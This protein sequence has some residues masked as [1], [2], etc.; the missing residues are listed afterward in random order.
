[1]NEWHL[2]VL[3]VSG[4]SA[5]FYIDGT[6]INTRTLSAALSTASSAGVVT[7]GGFTGSQYFVGNLQ[8]VRIYETPLD[9]QYVL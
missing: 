6:L 1:M 3:S 9:Q 2:L 7:V 5:S 8:D 4:I